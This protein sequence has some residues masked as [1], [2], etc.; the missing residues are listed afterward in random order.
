MLRKYNICW[1]QYLYNKF[2]R[3]R[4]LLNMPNAQIKIKSISSVYHQLAKQHPLCN[5]QFNHVFVN[6]LIHDAKTCVG[7]QFKTI[8]A[9]GRI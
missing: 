3:W 8:F 6:V 4:N 7:K 9:D 1:I 2:N 5:V